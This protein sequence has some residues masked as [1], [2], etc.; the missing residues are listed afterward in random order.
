MK[1]LK[2]SN[3]KFIVYF[4]FWFI[5]IVLFL[6]LFFTTIRYDQVQT[7]IFVFFVVLFVPSF[8]LFFVINYYFYDE[9][10]IIKI[11]ENGNVDYYNIKQLNF[12]IQDIDLCIESFARFPIGYTKI[13]L[14]NGYYFYVSNFISLESIYEMNP[15]IKRE[16]IFCPKI[17]R[18]KFFNILPTN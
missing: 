13:I 17:L 4:L 3:L 12:H 1:I 9:D 5:P 18:R 2:F 14:R 8:F 11:D 15:Q 10:T 7:Y 6:V 16:F